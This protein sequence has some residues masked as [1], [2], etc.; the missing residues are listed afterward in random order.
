MVTNSLYDEL[1]PTHGV[2]KG[3]WRGLLALFALLPSHKQTI[4]TVIVNLDTLQNNPFQAEGRNIK[5]NFAKVLNTI[6]P[7]L[8]IA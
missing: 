5:S 3:E 2:I 1:H 7:D 4:E 6:T 8:K